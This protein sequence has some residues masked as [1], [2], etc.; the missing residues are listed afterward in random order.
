MTDRIADPWGS[1][2]PYARG[3]EWPVR[4]DG[5]LQESPSQSSQ[6][7]ARCCLP[8]CSTRRSRDSRTRSSSFSSRAT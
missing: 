4:V 8:S 5:F 3:G 2:T 6:T 7:R 1:P